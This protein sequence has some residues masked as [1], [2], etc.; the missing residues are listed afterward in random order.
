MTN[1]TNIKVDFSTACITPRSP[2]DLHLTTPCYS[3]HSESK[4][5]LQTKL[6]PQHHVPP[7]TSTASF[8][9]LA[10]GLLA[11][12]A[13]LKAGKTDAKQAINKVP[14]EQHAMR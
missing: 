6:E 13:L 9:S 4:N 1:A 11:L 5:T 10:A 12:L 2:Q 8:G 3:H 14:G 7:C